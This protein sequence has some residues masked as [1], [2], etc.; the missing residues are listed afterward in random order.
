MVCPPPLR[1]ILAAPLSVPY[2]VTVSETRY[3]VQCTV[4]RYRIGSSQYTMHSVHV[5]TVQY[6]YTVLYYIHVLYWIVITYSEHE[7][8]YSTCRLVVKI[9]E[10]EVVLI[11][12]WSL[13]ISSLF[14]SGFN[15]A[16]V[17]LSCLLNDLT[18]R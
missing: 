15:D 9:L 18:I 3:Y 11:Y 14:N 5:C 7:S 13:I 12:I 4:C 17:S 6:G 1:Q 2:I 16:L 10:R 8:Q